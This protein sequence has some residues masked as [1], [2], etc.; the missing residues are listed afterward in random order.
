M[1]SKSTRLRRSRKQGDTPRKSP[2]PKR[3]SLSSTRVWSQLDAYQQDAVEFC[4]SV[5]T[6]GL[7]FEQGTGKTWIAGGLIEA[8]LSPSFVGLLVVPLSNLES[9]WLAFLTA[10]LPQL[11]LYRTWEEFKA[12]PAPKLLL[13]HYEAL[14]AKK[15]ID[16]LARVKWSLVGYDEGQRLKNRTSIESRNAAKLRKLAEYKL[17]LSGTPIEENPSD[18]WAQFRFLAPQVFGTRWKDFEEE[19]LEP[20]DND[21]LTRFKEAKP[22][23][24][25]W[26]RL[27]RDIRIA[28][29]KRRFDFTK[30]DAFLA[31]VSP[32]CLRET[33]EVLKLP[34]MSVQPVGIR[35]RG[36]QRELYDV[37]AR[38]MVADIDGGSQ[39][40]APLR[41]TQLG[42]LHQI[43][44]GYA[45]DDD[46]EVHEVG[47]AKQREL[48]KLIDKEHHKGPIVVFCRYLEEVWSLEKMLI[49]VYPSV[50]TLTGRN[51][52]ERSQLI[53]AFQAGQIDVMICQI[54]TGGVGIDLFRSC[55]AI[56][57]ST[58]YS[59]ID[60]EQ[61]LARIHRRGQTKPV[62]IYILIALDTIDGEIY[63]AIL[64][65]RRVTS[66]VL[67]HFEKRKQESV[68]EG[69]GQQRR[70]VQVRRS[71]HCR[72]AQGKRGNG[73]HE[74]A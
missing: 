24:Y 69:K 31:R 19:F 49:R 5:K 46:G 42:R 9:S 16:K 2:V 57:Y 53:E 47:R 10:Q 70:R 59:F 65:K 8:L 51:R 62:T 15:Y 67:I 71:R 21:L 72:R 63:S 74:A 56:F 64:D 55:V 1:L 30:L 34:P 48:K 50:K 41:I 52:K 32:F 14:K 17:L 4:L 61:A 11:P 38:D 73:A 54:K 45:T 39:V 20:I 60:F 23:S 6:A 7:F 13:Q 58:S 66:K 28:S 68:Q 36:Q 18:L 26:Q 40:T 33:K 43:C 35:L 12:A 29:G 27:L 25:K 3:P 44:G 22:R 37:L